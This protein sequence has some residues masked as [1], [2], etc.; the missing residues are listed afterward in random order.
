MRHRY[1][2]DE[3]VTADLNTNQIQRLAQYLSPYRRQIGITVVFMFVATMT[4]LLGPY[5]LQ[6]AIDV[7]LPNKDT[8][9]LLTI[10][11]GYLVFIIIG[12]FCNR[13]KIYLANRTGQSALLDIRRDLFD[14]VQGLSFGY[15][16]RTSPGRIIVR[17]VNDINTLNR[18]FTNG[19]INV[20]TELSMLV[21]AAFMMF[22]IHAELA[23][24]TFLTVPPFM[25]ALFLVRNTIKARWRNVRRK[26]SNLNAYIHE[27]IVGMRVIQAYVRQRVNDR[28]FHE[29]LDDTLSSWIHAVKLNS[30]FGPGI[31]LVSIIGTIVIF[32]YGSRLLQIDGISVGVVIAFTVYLR[33]F[34]H[35]IVTLSNFYNQLLVA[36]ASSERIFELMDEEPDIEDR[37]DAYPLP[38]VSGH[39]E[40]RHVNFSYKQDE[41]VLRDV[42]FSVKP[43]ETVALVGATGS[44]K[45]TIANLISRFY[46]PQ[47]GSVRIDGHDLSQVTEESIRRSIGIM[48]QDPFIF[49]GTILD[50]IRY[51][52]PDA[53]E[54]AAL[55]TAKAVRAHDFI[56]RMENGYST[57]VN[58]RGSRLSIGQ[59]QLL[60]FARALLTDPRIL[61]LDEATAN[62]DTHT[63][64]LIQQAI[65]RLLEGRTSFVIAHRLSTIRK[66]D[67]IMVVRKGRI[68]EMGS[69]DELMER[70]GIYHRLYTVQYRYLHAV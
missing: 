22:L 34:W 59:R 58:E 48:M 69:H 62:I 42:S 11:L 38:K 6:I 1:Q 44:G 67:R 8:A 65:E 25:V 32:W 56:E 37:P 28:V 64:V 60:C 50:N 15:F 49:S 3:A 4:E 14:H 27:N 55:R 24:V 53:S 30:A 13:Q 18:L 33:R 5:L 68:A 23:F 35:P 61:I 57:E 20:I 2:N 51:G 47:T 63:E 52:N 7:Y 54:E 39:V 16:A 46:V 9:G 19:I 43:G 12:Y 66:A 45:T 17:I 29:I 31:E 36:M 40:F 41:P 21:V 70:E 26:I 10:S